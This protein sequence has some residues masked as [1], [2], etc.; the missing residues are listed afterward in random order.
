M[1]EWLFLLLKGAK[2]CRVYVD[3]TGRNELETK[4]KTLHE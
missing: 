4:R 2:K 3:G 1:D